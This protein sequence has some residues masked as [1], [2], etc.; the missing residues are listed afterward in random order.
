MS[1]V[2]WNLRHKHQHKQPSMFRYKLNSKTRMKTKRLNV[3]LPLG[4]SRPS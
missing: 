4:R 3:R 2:H 1:T